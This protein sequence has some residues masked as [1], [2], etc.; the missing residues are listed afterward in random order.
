MSD[1]LTPST[2]AV[3]YSVA[4]DFSCSTRTESTSTP[5]IRE[6]QDDEDSP[7]DTELALADLETVDKALQRYAKAA[8][9]GDKHALAM[10][11]LLEKIQPHLNEAK[12]LRSFGLSSDDMLILRELNLLTVKPTMYIANVA[13]DGFTNN[14]LLIF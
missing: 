3:A 10:K 11:T 13:E 12:P 4:A 6:N 14:P 5:G 8:K 7:I 9:G 1:E 2:V